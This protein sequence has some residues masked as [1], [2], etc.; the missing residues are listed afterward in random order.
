MTQKERAIYLIQELQRE[1]P[2]FA[3]YDIPEEEEEQWMMFRGLCNVRPPFPASEEFLKIQDAYLQERVR[4]K[5]VTDCRALKPAPLDER[6]FLW[7]GDITTLQC[8]AIVNAANS[9][10]LGCF[11]MGHSCIDKATHIRITHPSSCIM[12]SC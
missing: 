2:E 10:M 5:G 8:D 4:E 9:Q 11:Q 6:L 12:A 3:R 7:K 1:L